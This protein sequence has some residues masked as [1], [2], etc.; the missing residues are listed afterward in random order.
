MKIQ[1]IEIEFPLP[2]ELPP[3]FTSALSEF[4]NLV[5]EKYEAEH[6]TRVMWPAG[7]GA[8]PLLREPY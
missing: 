2:V 6:P 3:G 7:H 5:C 1:K 8:K 4:I